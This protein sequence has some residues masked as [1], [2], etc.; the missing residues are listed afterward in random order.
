M[1]LG[2]T[3]RSDTEKMYSETRDALSR[4]LSAYVRNIFPKAVLIPLL[5]DGV[6]AV[7]GIKRLGING[8]I[9]SGGNTWGEDPVRDE[10]EIGILKFCL[11]NEIPMLGICRGMQVLV[12]FFGGRMEREIGNVSGESHAGTSH[13]IYLKDCDLIKSPYKNKKIKVN[14]YH[15]QGV[16][17]KNVSGLK[18]FAVTKGGVVEGIY[19][20]AKPIIGV[21]WH[22]ERK[23]ISAADLDRH[24]ITSLFKK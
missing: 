4:D 14:S 1:R 24:F 6:Q 11:R 12:I 3:M 21:Q 8:I 7:N 9:L 18:V 5:N 2:I 20:P 23:N 15:D 19:H 17:E 22:P 13:Y 10:T 16:L